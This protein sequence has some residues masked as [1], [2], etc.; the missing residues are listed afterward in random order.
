[1][2]GSHSITGV[3]SG[4]TNYIT[5]TSSIL[6]QNV[7]ASSS[8]TALTSDI[9]P[10]VFGQSVTFSATVTAVAPAS[11]TPTGTVDFF[12]GATNLGTGT[13]DGSGIATLAVSTLDVSG[14]PHSITA[15][16]SG[17][18]NFATSTSTAVLQTVNQADTTTNLT[19]DTNPSVFGQSVTFT[20]TVAPVSP[21]AGIPTGT[22]DFMDGATN[23][24]NG[25]VD[26][27]GTATFTTSALD[28]AGSPHS[29]TA[30]YVGDTNFATSTSTAVSQTVNQADTSTTVTSDANPSALDQTVTFTATVGVTSPG[31]GTPTG[32]VEFFDGTTSL[33]TG[34]LTSGQATVVTSSLA[35][36]F[37]FD[38]RGLLR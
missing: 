9:N 2:L 19:S 27:N 18:T 11:G 6:T 14:S 15:D 38:H 31:N 12:D 3:Y 34:T 37:P 1:M 33:G 16:Y 29:I 32:T 20:A 28:V 26:G 7:V 25:T 24:G 17:D 4:D 21:G 8:A 10:S 22:V 13:L 35:P 30:V 23:I 5:S 36:G